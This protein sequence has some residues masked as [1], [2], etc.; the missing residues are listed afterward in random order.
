MSF[1][2]ALKD[3]LRKVKKFNEDTAIPA[4]EIYTGDYNSHRIAFLA[5][6]GHEVYAERYYNINTPVNKAVS[7]HLNNELLDLLLAGRKHEMLQ[8]ALRFKV[9]ACSKKYS[10]QTICLPYEYIQYDIVTI[11]ETL[12]YDRD[13]DVKLI[14]IMSAKEFLS[15]REHI[16]HIDFN[17]HD[18]QF[19]LF[20][21]PKGSTHLNLFIE[22]YPDADIC[23]YLGFVF[24]SACSD[25]SEEDLFEVETFDD[26]KEDIYII[27]YRKET[28]KD[29]FYFMPDIYD[30]LE[31]IR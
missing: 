4:V 29:I 25:D 20:L 18:K 10:A 24:T 9:S 26:P 27:A 19:R 13:D 17:V 28:N 14:K 6:T 1:E 2:K 23:I 5:P 15:E 21:Y 30:Y 3:F 16:K 11:G 7:I 12:V 31:V 22:R 8:N